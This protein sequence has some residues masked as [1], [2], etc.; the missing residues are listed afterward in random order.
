MKLLVLVLSVAL[1]FTAGETLNCHR[2]VP[3]RAGGECELTEET[4][5]PEKNGCAAARF[6]RKPSTTCATPYKVQYSTK[7]ENKK[8][9]TM[10]RGIKALKPN[11]SCRLQLLQ[12]APNCEDVYEF[13]AALQRSPHSSQ[14]F[15]LT[16]KKKK[17]EKV[18]VL[19]FTSRK[20]FS[21]YFLT[22][23]SIQN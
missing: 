7:Q 2:C 15:P 8:E 5:K 13:N 23:T 18:P 4:C 6:L 21:H 1:L 20:E 10:Y 17:S 19:I 14:S 9:K 22:A 3:Q 11:D 12:V 16:N